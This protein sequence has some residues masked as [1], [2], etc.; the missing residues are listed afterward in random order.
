MPSNLNLGDSKLGVIVE[1]LEKKVFYQK[2]IWNSIGANAIQKFNDIKIQIPE[3]SR[4][5]NSESP[6]FI[7]SCG[8]EERTPYPESRE[9]GF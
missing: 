3:K 1:K 7:G 5:V 4:H 2:K 8:L 6:N 9:S